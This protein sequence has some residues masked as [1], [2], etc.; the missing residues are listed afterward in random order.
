MRFSQVALSRFRNAPIIPKRT[1]TCISTSSSHECRTCERMDDMQSLRLVL[2]K[3][4]SGIEL[5]ETCTKLMPLCSSKPSSEIE[6]WERKKMCSESKIPQNVEKRFQ[7]H[8]LQTF[9]EAPLFCCGRDNTLVKI[10]CVTLVSVSR[11]SLR[12][13]TLNSSQSTMFDDE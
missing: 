2:S 3:H 12:I 4:T 7:L 10:S 11:I 8:A 6:V 13:C 1:V 5:R 9:L